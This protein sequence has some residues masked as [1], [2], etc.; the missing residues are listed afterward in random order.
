MYWA[1]LLRTD[2]TPPIDTPVEDRVV[3]CL[4][5]GVPPAEDGPGNERRF[6]CVYRLGEGSYKIRDH[7]LLLHTYLPVTLTEYPQ[8]NMA[9]WYQ[10]RLEQGMRNALSIDE[11]NNLI[12]R[13][14]EAVIYDESSQ[15]NS[16]ETTPRPGKI[17][18]S[19]SVELGNTESPK[20]GYS[21]LQCN[22]A[23]PTILCT[24]LHI[25]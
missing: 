13:M 11:I 22:A 10:R 3:F 12:R 21:A 16:R 20:S 6:R 5:N 24:W 23:I 19:C 7:H 2:F 1:E 15:P 18:T 14:E 4:A 9:T 25:Q 8:F 17:L